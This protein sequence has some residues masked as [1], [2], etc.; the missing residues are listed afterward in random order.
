MLFCFSCSQL[1][2][3]GRVDSVNVNL[4]INRSYEIAYIHLKQVCMN[5]AENNY[6]VI[7]GE[8]EY[9]ENSFIAS[10]AGNCYLVNWLTGDEKCLGSLDSSE[11]QN[12]ISAMQ[13]GKVRIIV[14]K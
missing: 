4:N 12:L 13:K 7:F 9:P 2:A 6:D 14:Q 3:E 1:K 10:R 11:V 5:A 8:L